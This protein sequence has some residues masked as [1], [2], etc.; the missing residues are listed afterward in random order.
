MGP[1]T[2]RIVK[3][4]ELNSDVDNSLMWEVGNFHK[5]HHDCRVLSCF[6]I[7]LC[8]MLAKPYRVKN[9]KAP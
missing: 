8:K 2:G 3:I 1:Y 5:Y 9:Q 6:E 4:E 7:T